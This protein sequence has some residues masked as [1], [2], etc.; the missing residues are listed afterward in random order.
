[1]D[2]KSTNT[3]HPEM[4]SL[5]T[6]KILYKSSS[7]EDSSDSNAGSSDTSRSDSSGS[8]SVKVY[9]K[10]NRMLLDKDSDE[11]RRRREKNNMAVRKSRNK[12]KL[13]TIEAVNRVNLLRAEN[14]KLQQKI[15]AL[16]QELNLLRDLSISHAINTE[17]EE[18]G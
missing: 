6:S 13:R 7:F 12:C 1:M 18:I 15:D 5:I 11:Y 14:E 9:A 10:V 16:S 3:Y 2:L 17:L 4:T 8:S